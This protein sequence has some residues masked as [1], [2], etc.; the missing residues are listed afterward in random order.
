M[1]TLYLFAVLFIFT[2]LLP[3]TRISHWVVRVWDFVRLQTSAAQFITL[4]LIFLLNY[5]TL[6]WQWVV[7]ITLFATIV[8]QLSIIFPYTRYFPFQHPKPDDYR[9]YKKISLLTANVLQPNEEYE[10]FKHIVDDYDPDIFLTMESHKG[11]EEKLEELEDRYPYSIK[12]P[13]DNLYGMHLYSKFELSHKEVNYLVEEGVPSMYAQVHYHLGEPLNLFCVHPAPPSPTENAT[14]KERD[15]EL[16]IVGRR[17]RKLE[18]PIVV[19][20]DLNDV[21]WSRVSRLF[22]KMTGLIDPR[23][24]RGLFSTFHADYWFLRFPI[25]HMFHSDDISVVR[26]ERLSHFGSD[27]FPMFFT[28]WIEN[29]GED[30]TSPELDPETNEDIE[31]VIEEGLEEAQDKHPSNS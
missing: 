11:W 25:D 10:K 26:M 24:G 8:Y 1:T 14:S 15:A 29:D 28:I 18:S 27:H 23:M 21:V 2:S 22:T 5:P 19:C 3:F 20:G 6:W 17:V 7:V 30:N 12:E 13:L 4:I 16:L 31:E 9:N